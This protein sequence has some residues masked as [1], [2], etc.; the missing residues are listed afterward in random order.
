LADVAVRLGIPLGTAKSRL[1]HRFAFDVRIPTR[2]T[3]VD[4][5]ALDA[6][7][8]SIDIEP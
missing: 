7:I 2:T 8:A 4:R 1:H 5:A 6:V 3:A